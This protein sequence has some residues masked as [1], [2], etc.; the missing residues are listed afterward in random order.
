MSSSSK[1]PWGGDVGLQNISHSAPRLEPQF[2]IKI[3]EYNRSPSRFLFCLSSDPVLEQCRQSLLAA[4]VQHDFDRGAKVYV[5]LEYVGRVLAYL[6]TCGVVLNRDT[7]AP[8]F[9]ADLRPRH[10]IVIDSLAHRL[11]NAARCCPSRDKVR[12]TRSQ[13]LVFISVKF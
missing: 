3:I 11:D 5:P 2:V 13:C 1:E 7:D 10:C 9:L 6:N 4:S 12:P 8:V